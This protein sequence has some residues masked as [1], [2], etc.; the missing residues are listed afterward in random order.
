[1][2]GD[3]KIFESVLSLGTENFLRIILS[4]AASILVGRFLGPEQYGKYNYVISLVLIFSPLI[5]FSM[6]EVIVK[7]VVEG[8]HSLSSIFSSGLYLRVLLG[9]LGAL[10]CFGYAFFKEGYSPVFV[11]V[12]IYG[13]FFVLKSFDI[14][15]YFFIA[16]ERIRELAKLRTFIFIGINLFKGA[17]VYWQRDWKWFVYLSALELLLVFFLYIFKSREESWLNLR[18]KFDKGLAKSM[19]S[20][21]FPFFLITTMTILFARVDHVMIWDFLG[22]KNLGEY[23]VVV[24]WGEFLNFIPLMLTSAFLPRIIADSTG[25]KSQVALK[26]FFRLIFLS[27]LAIAFFFLL[28]G[29]LFIKTLYGS[30][31]SKAPDIIQYY[32]LQVCLS[33]LYVA[34]VRYLLIVDKMRSAIELYG[35][36]LLFN[37]VIN[38]LLIPRMGLQGAVIASIA[39]YI[40]AL[41]LGLFRDSDIRR[42]SALYFRSL[43]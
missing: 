9:L 37:L 31:F 20:R 4:A 2:F 21:S 28:I 15:E 13:S 29:P 10:L 22:G 30:S 11:L 40:F 42:G 1:M 27:S 32:S 34:L 19:F 6:N 17:F 25:E 24:K 18:L 5:N 36:S 3:R 8:K 33:F 39:S 35:F 7:Q 26:N 12:L 43:F 38:Y 16:K 23:A 14:I 41:I